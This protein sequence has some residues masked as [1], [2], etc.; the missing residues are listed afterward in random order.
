MS[1]ET[2]STPIPSSVTRRTRSNRKTFSCSG[3]K[4]VGSSRIRTPPL[5][6]VLLA[7]LAQL[8]GSAH[9]RQQRLGRRAQATHLRAGVEI[10]PVAL[11]DLAGARAL[12]APVDRRR[13]AETARRA[14]PDEEVLDH[15]KLAGET[16]ILVDEG[17]ADHARPAERHRERHVDAVQ[18]Q[19]AARLGLVV[20]GED[21]D[22]RRLAGAVLAQQRDD[23]AGV[24]RDV[25][26]AE[27][28]EGA[29]ALGEV[30]RLE[31]RRPARSRAPP[32]QYDCSSLPRST[33]PSDARGVAYLVT[34]HSFR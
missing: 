24:D 34:P 22:E 25:D 30:P 28:L 12:G 31:R 8:F 10:D 21:L 6:L 16:E 32:D 9:D 13:R 29:E 2:N 20:A 5:S 17:K 26:A 23:L 27:R 19:L 14:V 3:R 11:E 18:P 15:V 33:D 7:V 1:W 4:T